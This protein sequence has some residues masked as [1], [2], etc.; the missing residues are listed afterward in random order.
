MPSHLTA[1]LGYGEA[2][3]LLLIVIVMVIMIPI[4]LLMGYFSD[5]IGA[6]KI[7]QGG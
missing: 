4:V 2:E 7:I 1:V 6:K 3:G 5:R